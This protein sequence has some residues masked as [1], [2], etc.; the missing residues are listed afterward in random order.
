M[1]ILKKIS[2]KLIILY[3][4]DFVLLIILVLN[5]FKIRYYL[6]EPKTVDT[7]KCFGDCT[8]HIYRTDSK[9]YFFDCPKYSGIYVTKY[10]ETKPKIYLIGYFKFGITF[11]HEV[12]YLIY[13]MKNKEYEEYHDLDTMSKSDYEVFKRE[14][15]FYAFD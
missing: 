2:Y 5:Y 15:E 7:V 10:L 13:D 6:Y 1:K 3:I 14:D 4:V 9:E 8:V 12:A 11:E